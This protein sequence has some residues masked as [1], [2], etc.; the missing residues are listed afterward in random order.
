MYFVQVCTLPGFDT[1]AQ[2]LYLWPLSSKVIFF[3]QWCLYMQHSSIIKGKKNS[4]C[5]EA[6][7]GVGG[8]GWECMYR[9]GG[10]EGEEYGGEFEA[11]L[12][13]LVAGL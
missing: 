4:G 6:T 10:G 3:L 2:L 13:R 5:I 11:A 9:V 8:L 1:A 7:C 12:Q